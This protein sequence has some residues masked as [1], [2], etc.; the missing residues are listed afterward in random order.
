MN[1]EQEEMKEF[2]EEKINELET[3]DING[4]ITDAEVEELEEVKNQLT[5]LQVEMGDV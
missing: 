1:L 2:L 5:D 3:A 4:I